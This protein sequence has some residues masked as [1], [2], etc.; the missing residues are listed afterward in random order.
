VGL[1]EGVGLYGTMMW[2]VK[3][4]RGVGVF[5]GVGDIYQR[6][7]AVGVCVGG[8]TGEGV[9]IASGGYNSNMALI[10]S[11]PPG[12]ANSL[13]RAA[14]YEALQLINAGRRIQP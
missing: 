14:E 2:G 1:V 5:V 6:K 13:N 3:V 7:V 12:E 10:Q 9:I 11:F 8:K 4:G